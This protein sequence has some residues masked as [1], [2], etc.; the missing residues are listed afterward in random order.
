MTLRLINW[1]TLT[2]FWGGSRGRGGGGRGSSGASVGRNPIS[3]DLNFENF[4][5]EDPPLTLLHGDTPSPVRISNPPLLKLASVPGLGISLR[6]R[7]FI[8]CSGEPWAR[9]CRAN[10]L[11]PKGQ[12]R[13]GKHQL[14][15]WGNSD[16]SQLETPRLSGFHPNLANWQ[17][18]MTHLRIVKRSE[19]PG[20]LVLYKKIA[21]FD[22][23]KESVS[24]TQRKNKLY[25]N[26]SSS[27]LFLIVLDFDPS[28]RSLRMFL[29]LEAILQR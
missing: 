13:F 27:L 16:R 4:P 25:S 19:P 23:R 2:S 26:P 8:V 18:K 14:R 12:E 21:I 5:R 1:R 3:E 15:L 7:Q 29:F 28:T 9:V 10:I 20:F 24:I 22:G 17:S 6:Q 11:V